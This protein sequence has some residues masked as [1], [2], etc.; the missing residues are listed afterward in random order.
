MKIKLHFDFLKICR[1]ENIVPNGLAINKLSAVGEQDK[2]F[3]N[4]RN[5]ILRE[6]S[7]KLMECLLEHYERQLAHN[8]AKLAESYESIEKL[9]HWT[10]SDEAHVEEEIQSTLEPKEKQL[11]EKQRKLEA[12]RRKKTNQ[13]TPHLATGTYAGVLK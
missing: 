8:V 11:K 3:K 12:A 2:T 5:G 7:K 13:E 1:E 6:C 9:E 10:A 4:K